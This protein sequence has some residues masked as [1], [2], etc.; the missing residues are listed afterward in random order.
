VEIRCTFNGG[1]AILD[2]TGR[3]VVSP[4]ETEILPLRAAVT[5]LI[6]EGRTLVALN[7]AGLAAIDAR[8]LGELVFTLK[9]LRSCGGNLMLIAP[10]PAVR[11]LLAATKLDAILPL[12]DSP[13]SRQ[14]EA[15][16]DGCPVSNLP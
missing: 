11:R 14:P 4:G 7:L 10:P 2:L 13:S 8:G 16:A 3:F 1:V 6:A 12:C 15:H 5:A 9:T